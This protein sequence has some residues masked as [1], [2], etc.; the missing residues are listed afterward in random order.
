MDRIDL[1]WNVPSPGGNIFVF[2]YPFDID[3]GVTEEE[4]TYWAIKRLW[5]NWSSEIS[6][7]KVEHLKLWLLQKTNKEC[8]ENT[9]WIKVVKITQIKFC[10]RNLAYDTV[11]HYV[12][13]MTKGGV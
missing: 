9:W 1:Y 11:W 8:L 12:V 7:M 3:D 4:D 13:L 6:G 5:L 10:G 2:L